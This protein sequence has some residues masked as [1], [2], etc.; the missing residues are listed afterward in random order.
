[1]N[2]TEYLCLKRGQKV[3][4]YQNLGAPEEP[5]FID[6]VPGS[7]Y[8]SLVAICKIIDLYYRYSS[9]KNTKNARLMRCANYKN[10]RS[11]LCQAKI[12]LI[13]ERPEFIQKVIY[14]TDTGKKM[15]KFDINYAIARDPKNWTIAIF[16]TSIHSE[17]CSNQ[18]MPDKRIYDHSLEGIDLQND[19]KKCTKNSVISH[20][21]GI[22]RMGHTMLALQ[23]K[24]NEIGTIEE[25]M[26]LETLYSIEFTGLNIN[27]DNEQRSFQYHRYK[28]KGAGLV[29]IHNIPAGLENYDFN[30]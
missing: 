22:Y 4:K 16:N 18:P 5:Y 9:Y 20:F 23:T 3:K 12:K 13:P 27:L 21:E 6:F 10:K 24:H 30:R 11:N 7:H 17:W 28:D 25:I 29:I 15:T 1:M 8:G 2:T 14:Y 26:N 19:R